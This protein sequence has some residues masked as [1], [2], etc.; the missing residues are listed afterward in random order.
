MYEGLHHGRRRFAPWRLRTTDADLLSLSMLGAYRSCVLTAYHQ[1]TVRSH[2]TFAHSK[3]TK[4]LCEGGVKP[5]RERVPALTWCAMNCAK[6]SVQNWR[7]PSVRCFDKRG[8][9]T[10]V[11]RQ[12]ATSGG[13]CGWS[14]SRV[15]APD[16]PKPW[17]PAR[18]PTDLVSG[19]DLVK[20][21][22]LSTQKPDKS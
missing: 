20:H 3:R 12:T 1:H 13:H 18:I 14:P 15:P 5:C 22:V 9:D 10:S 21:N 19:S 6:H 4:T 8:S 2:G 7:Q 17:I 11:N 16:L